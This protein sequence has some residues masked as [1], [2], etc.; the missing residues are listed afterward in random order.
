M[1]IKEMN[2]DQKYTLAKAK[3]YKGTKEDIK[4]TRFL[5]KML[6]LEKE[7]RKLINKSGGLR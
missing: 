5:F 3:G 2:L 6:K 7:Q 4:I 1:L